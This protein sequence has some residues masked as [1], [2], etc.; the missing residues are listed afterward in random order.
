[1]TD[2]Q[3]LIGRKT[4][5]PKVDFFDN[6]E[7]T[8]ETTTGVIAAIAE[9]QP[10]H[11]VVRFESGYRARI[12]KALAEACRPAAPAAPNFE[13][14]ISARIHAWATGSVSCTYNGTEYRKE[15]DD[16][17]HRIGC[18]NPDDENPQECARCRRTFKRIYGDPPV[19]H[20]ADRVARFLAFY[21]DRPTNVI[22]TVAGASTGHKDVTLMVSDL[23]YLVD[24]H[25]QRRG[26]VTSPKE[27]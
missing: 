21:S 24:F 16:D 26:L 3:H 8:G 14:Y 5:A 12:T 20:P 19:G 13:D 15:W 6:S 25:A 4:T 23:Q 27:G 7:I 1:M 11:L 22:L 10:D 9:V 18:R 2:Y 17:D